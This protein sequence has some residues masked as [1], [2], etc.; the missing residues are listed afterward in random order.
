MHE[1][2]EREKEKAK[3][4]YE[5]KNVYEVWQKIQWLTVEGAIRQNESEGIASE[6]T[7]V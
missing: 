6:R 7:R 2:T 1:L 5:V 4:E 3:S